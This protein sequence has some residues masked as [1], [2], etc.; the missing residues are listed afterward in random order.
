MSTIAVLGMGLLGSGFAENL[1][2]KGHA[3]QVWN[4]SPAKCAPLVALGATAGSTPA[5]AVAGADRVHLVLAEDDAV[6][7]VITALLPS[8]APGATIVDHSTNLPHRVGER[9][10]RLR[11]QGVR[12][13]HAPVFMAP[14]NAR[15]GTGLMLLS[16]PADEAQALQPA[17]AEM[18]GKVW[19]VGERADAAATLKL[20]GNGL[21]IALAGTMGDLYQLAEHNG[22]HATDVLTL[23]ETFNP[24]PA[25]LGKRVLQAGTVPASFELSMARKDVRLMI[26]GAG[27]PEHL[28]VLPGL[29][30]AMDRD[31]AAGLGAEDFAIFAKPR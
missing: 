12:Y 23:F 5:Q 25:Y 15:Q 21:L 24:S 27:G 3:V 26:E 18:T 31:L 16:G 1:L 13:L 7:A 11:E 28:S 9:T 17:L 22:L 2:R 8:L 30:A 10:T 6:D 19:H 14:S 29:A 20:A 4:R